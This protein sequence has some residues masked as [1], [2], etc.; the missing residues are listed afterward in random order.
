MTAS[1]FPGIPKLMLDATRKGRT[2]TIEAVTV[3][4]DDEARRRDVTFLRREFGFPLPAPDWEIVDEEGLVLLCR[5]GDVPVGAVRLLK[6]HG[7]ASDW[8]PYLT[9]ALRAA[10]P[11]DPAGFVFMERLVVSPDVR[12]LEVL[13]VI[14]HAAATWTP[15]LWDVAEFAAITRPELVRL[16][17]W[18][19]ARQLSEPMIL[20]G[21]DGLG[22]LIGGGLEEAAARTKALF[23]TGGWRLSP[24]GDLPTALA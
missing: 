18:L 4:A 11:A 2:F 14:M 12:S 17:G 23:S 1:L 7:G 20:P 6:R 8:C 16:A 19:G 3:S 9:A 10:L 5:T 22:L 24:V 13:A 15:V 21:S